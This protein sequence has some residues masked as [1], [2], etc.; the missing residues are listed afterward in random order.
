[1]MRNQTYVAV[2]GRGGGHKLACLNT[3]EES[4]IEQMESTVEKDEVDSQQFHYEFDQLIL[5]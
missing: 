2:R 4:M 5:L 3:L 1:M